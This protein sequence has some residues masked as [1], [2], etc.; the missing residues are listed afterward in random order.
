MEENLEIKEKDLDAI[1]F[2][3]LMNWDEFTNEE[4]Q[5]WYNILSEIDLEFN[6]YD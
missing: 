2:Y 1:Y 4:K 5:Y 3:I 6:D